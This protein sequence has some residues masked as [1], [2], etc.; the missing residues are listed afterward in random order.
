MSKVRDAPLEQVLLGERRR[1]Q[2]PGRA[3]PSSRRRR[4]CRSRGR[5]SARPSVLGDVAEL[6]LVAVGARGRVDPR[7]PAEGRLRG[8]ERRGAGLRRLA[9]AGRGCDRVELEPG[10]DGRGGFPARSVTRDR[11]RAAGSCRGKPGPWVVH[12]ASAHA[13]AGE[14]RAAV[15]CRAW[16]DRRARGT[17]RP[18]SA[19]P[20]RVGAEGRARPCRTAKFTLARRRGSVVGSV[21]SACSAPPGKPVSVTVPLPWTEPSRRS[22]P[23][24]GRGP[25]DR[26]RRPG[27]RCSTCG[28]RRVPVLAAARRSAIEGA[29]T[30]A[31]RPGRASRGAGDRARPRAEEGRRR[32]SGAPCFAWNIRRFAPAPPPFGGSLLCRTART[33]APS[34]RVRSPLLRRAPPGVRPAASCRSRFLLATQKLLTPSGLPVK[35]PPTKGQTRQT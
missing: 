35:R 29:A 8:D 33:P 21:P 1:P 24:A 4:R 16:P 3:A 30:A 15:G 18:R 31:A 10:R 11:W 6:E 34:G 28:V 17:S 5:S 26:A 25:G 22:E 2:R 20:T 14:A 13:P 12:G 19:R 7:R 9:A 32:G 27:L 23:D